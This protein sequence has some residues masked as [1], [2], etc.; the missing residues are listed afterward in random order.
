MFFGLAQQRTFRMSAGQPLVNLLPM[1]ERP[2]K[3][4]LHEV[5]NEEYLKVGSR[6]RVFTYGR[7]KYKKNREF[8][9]KNEGR[10]PFGFDKK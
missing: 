5:S 6:D 1:S 3:I 10:C 4:H 7:N 2:V 8:L 9:Q